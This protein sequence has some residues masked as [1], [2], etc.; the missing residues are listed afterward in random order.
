MLSQL[1]FQ[2]DVVQEAYHQEQQEAPQ[3]LPDL[4]QGLPEIQPDIPQHQ[5]V[6]EESLPLVTEPPPTPIVQNEQTLPHDEASFPYEPIP[7]STED[8]GKIPDFG[9]TENDALTS[10]QSAEDGDGIVKYYLESS[11][12][13]VSLTIHDMLLSLIDLLT[14]SCFV[15][16]RMAT[17]INS[18]EIG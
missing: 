13:F 18:W 2:P 5:T 11:K 10:S 7:P 3:G 6:V 14:L 8:L 4:N 1:L 9:A 17:Q 16:S 15:D 12:D